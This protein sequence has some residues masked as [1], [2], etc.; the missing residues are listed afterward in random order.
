MEDFSIALGW[1]GF[2]ACIFFGW[3]FYLKARNKERMALI[4]KNADLSEIYKTKEIKFRFPWLKLGMI[5]TGAGL[6]LLLC[7]LLMVIPA[8]Q[9]IIDDTD[10]AVVFAVIL[11]FGG[12]SIIGAYYLDRPKSR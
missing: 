2:F 10:G 12:L 7:T 5:I 8:F 1:L 9:N 6:G 11:F 3:Y 4:E